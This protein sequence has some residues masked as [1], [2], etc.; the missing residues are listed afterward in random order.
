M[1]RHLPD[2]PVFKD[3]TAEIPPGYYN[4]IRLAVLRRG[5]VLDQVLGLRGLEFR[6]SPDTWLCVDRRLGHRPVLA[7]TDFATSRPALHQPVR[8]RLL[9]YDAYAAV[10]VQ[11]VLLEL[12]ERL[13]AD[14][15]DQQ[16]ATSPRRRIVAFP[17][18]LR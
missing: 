4:R 1:K 14:A 9:Y 15:R 2:L 7:W 8:C 10:L 3:L 6:L 11:S 12:S 16:Q 18:P 5:P 13:A 17:R